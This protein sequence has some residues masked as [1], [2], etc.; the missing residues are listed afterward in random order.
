MSIRQMQHSPA[1]SVNMSSTPPQPNTAKK[2]NLHKAISKVEKRHIS[3]YSR[4]THRATLRIWLKGSETSVW[5]FFFG[6]QRQPCAMQSP[7]GGGLEPFP[8]FST[9]SDHSWWIFQCRN[10]F[11]VRLHI[12]LCQETEINFMPLL[13]SPSPLLQTVVGVDDDSC[14]E[15]GSRGSNN[16]CNLPLFQS[17]QFGA[18]NFHVRKFSALP[19]GQKLFTVKVFLNRTRSSKALYAAW[20]VNTHSSHIHIFTTYFLHLPL[21]W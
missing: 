16:Y 8:W 2:K 11:T 12:L 17:Y 19:T 6:G 5:V 10:L 1:L 13:T 7:N 9:S 15:T 3:N 21:H 20:S 14:T 18:I 4:L